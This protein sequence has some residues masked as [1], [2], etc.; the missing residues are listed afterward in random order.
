MDNLDHSRQSFLEPRLSVATRHVRVAIIGLSGGGSQIVQQ[1]AHI[2]F[3]RFWLFDPDNIELSNLTR[4]V[5]ATLDDVRAKRPKVEI[6]SRVIRGVCP[7]PEIHAYRSTWQEQAADLRCCDLVFGCLDTFLAR[8]DLEVFCRRYRIP[9]IDIGMDVSGNTSESFRM[10]GQAVLSMPGGPCMFCQ[11][12]LTEEALAREGTRYG[13][14]GGRPQ[15]VWA[16]GVLA[17]TAV[18][19]A[20]DLLTGWTSH[21]VTPFA[22][23][24][25]NRGTVGEDARLGF[26]PSVCCHYSA[27]DVGDPRPIAV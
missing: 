7:D 24:D 22:S 2:G 4:L 14:V 21:T 5:G 23:F 13:A 17:S 11:R 9:L 25:G 6:A 27:N 10:Y 20:L 12:Y 3:H 18:G 8:R 16:N 26:A 1:L 15:V 19:M